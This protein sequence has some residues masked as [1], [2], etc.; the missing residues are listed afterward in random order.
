M[1]PGETPEQAAVRELAEET[2][3]RPGRVVPLGVVHPNP[4][5]QTNRCHH[6][7]GLECTRD[8]SV[9]LDEGEDI[10][11]ELRPFSESASLFTSGAITHSLVASAFW[12]ERL[13]REQGEQAAPTAG[14]FGR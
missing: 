13:W 12:F 5:F 8:S 6:F 7:L 4:A 2:G 3:Y 11:V 1:D 9:K 10:A 14:A